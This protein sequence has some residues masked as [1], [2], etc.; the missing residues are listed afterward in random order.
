[1]PFLARHHPAMLSARPSRA[2]LIGGLGAVLLIAG[3]AL[4]WFSP[5]GASEYGWFAYAPLSN[6]DYLP[7]TRSGL[8]HG[9]EW[10]RPGRR[11]CC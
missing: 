8:A 5:T 3:S 7:P 11:R 10:G 4:Y 2:T 9:R 6:A 1:M